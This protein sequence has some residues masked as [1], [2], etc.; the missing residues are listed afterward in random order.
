MKAKFFWKSYYIAIISRKKKSLFAFIFY[1]GSKYVLKLYGPLLKVCI[2]KICFSNTNTPRLAII[3][4]LNSIS[5]YSLVVL[6]ENIVT[7]LKYFWSHRGYKFLLKFSCK[8]S[9]F[10]L[11]LR[12]FTF[13]KEI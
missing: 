3:G 11:H 4:N 12:H 13:Y 10:D 5:Q 1:K 9:E 2:F 8:G 6:N 7:K